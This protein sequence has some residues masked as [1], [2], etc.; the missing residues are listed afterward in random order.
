VVAVYVWVVDGI[1]MK[2]QRVELIMCKLD[3]AAEERCTVEVMLCLERTAEIT[4][5]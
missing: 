4:Y 2:M 3:N 1:C 5:I